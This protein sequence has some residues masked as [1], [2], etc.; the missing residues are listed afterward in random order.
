MAVAGEADNSGLPAHALPLNLSEF[1][2]KISHR[3]VYV[4]DLF[5]FNA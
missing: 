4:L 2:S 1:R 5:K 3:M